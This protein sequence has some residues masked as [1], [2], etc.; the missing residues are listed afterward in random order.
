MAAILSRGRWVKLETFGVLES[1]SAT[2][3]HGSHRGPARPLRKYRNLYRKN[4]GKIQDFTGK[5][6]RKKRKNKGSI[7]QLI[8]F[9]IRHPWYLQIPSIHPDRLQPWLSPSANGE[10]PDVCSAWTDLSQDGIFR[11]SLEQETACW[12]NPGS[13]SCGLTLWPPSPAG[14]PRPSV[15]LV[16]YSW[17]ENEW[18]SLSKEADDIPTSTGHPTTGF[19]TTCTRLAGFAIAGQKQPGEPPPTL[20]DC[21]A[22]CDAFVGE[23][24][25]SWLVLL[26]IPKGLVTSVLANWG[27]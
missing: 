2:L 3:P 8:Y 15:D 13:R 10:S 12:R 11:S 21:Q 24:A 6:L 23:V 20:L 26:S 14:C 25:V 19:L 27:S 9:F 5:N 1:S 18:A 16:S 4:F 17:L 7:K 22:S